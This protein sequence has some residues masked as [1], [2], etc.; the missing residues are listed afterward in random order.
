MSRQANPAN[1]TFVGIRPR[2]FRRR[3]LRGRSEL[4]DCETG[5]P[6]DPAEG[7]RVY[8][9]VTVWSYP[10]AVRH[11]W[12]PAFGSIRGFTLFAGISRRAGCT[13]SREADRRC[14][15]ALEDSPVRYYCSLSR[16]LA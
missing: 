6:N 12:K 7:K 9:I 11:D 14:T 15:M 16:R 5:V 8:R 13:L 10:H 1:E 4:L 3:F 2:L